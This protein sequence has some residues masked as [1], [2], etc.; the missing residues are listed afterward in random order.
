ME[1]ISIAATKQ[2]LRPHA[3]KLH[4]PMHVRDVG[5]MIKQS[6]YALLA[7][8]GAPPIRNVLESITKQRSA[9]EAAA[10]SDANSTSTSQEQHQQYDK[11][12]ILLVGPEGD[13][14][15]EEIEMLVGA[16]A[17]LVGLGRNRL[18]TE[19]AAIALLS[20][21]MLLDV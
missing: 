10:G 8:G 13:W 18:R 12:R 16:G 1:R 7:E 17:Y 5:D 20:H 11:A 15:P 14:T 21:V 6:D 3:L 2:C 4:A 9:S 19:T